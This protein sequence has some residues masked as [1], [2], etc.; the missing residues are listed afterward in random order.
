[1]Y[2]VK[3]SVLETNLHS[4]PQ[5]LYV[6]GNYFSRQLRGLDKTSTLV[7]RRAEGRI[8]GKI[9]ERLIYSVEDCNRRRIRG[10]NDRAKKER[11]K[12]DAGYLVPGSTR[13]VWPKWRRDN[14]DSWKK[15]KYERQGGTAGPGDQDSTTCRAVR[16]SALSA[17]GRAV[18]LSCAHPRL[19]MDQFVL[20]MWKSAGNGTRW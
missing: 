6:N 16:F 10:E 20:L 13:K 4:Q 5:K 9:R 2:R 19:A 1:M 15:R 12:A 7:H 18:F 3:T 14:L 17:W 11:K 8:A